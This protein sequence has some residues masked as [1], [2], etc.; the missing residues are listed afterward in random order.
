MAISGYKPR[1]FSESLTLPMLQQH[2]VGR[3]VSHLSRGIAGYLKFAVT[4]AYF[5]NSQRKEIFSL[6]WNQVI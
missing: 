1:T 5:R 2:K 6:Q 4:F 3:R